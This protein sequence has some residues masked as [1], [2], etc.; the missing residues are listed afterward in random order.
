MEHGDDDPP[1]LLAAEIVSGK[2]RDQ[3]GDN[4]RRDPIEEAL[5]IRV[6]LIHES[7]P[8]SAVAPRGLADRAST[9]RTK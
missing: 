7:L 6:P 3:C 4:D 9:R 1:G 2:E 8:L 5:P